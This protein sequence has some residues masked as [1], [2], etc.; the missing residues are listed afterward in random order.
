[1]LKELINKLIINKIVEEM[2]SSSISLE[3]NYIV[4]KI[5]EN[6]S[7]AQVPETIKIHILISKL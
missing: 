3:K 5:S 4:L 1:M 6:L 2:V 7:L